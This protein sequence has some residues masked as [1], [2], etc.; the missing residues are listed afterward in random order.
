MAEKQG[1][2]VLPS[3]THDGRAIVAVQLALA[4]GL[5]VAGASL[6]GARV[7]RGVRRTANAISILWQTAP[8]IPAGVKSLQALL[9]AGWST[10]DIMTLS[11]I[12]A[13]LS[14]Q[15]RVAAGLRVLATA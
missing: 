1:F 13:F 9:N 14:F 4:K 7:K 2:H 5:E 10:T 3:P 11:Q 6:D 8:R 15:I 12:I